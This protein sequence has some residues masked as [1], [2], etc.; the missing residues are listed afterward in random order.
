MLLN[1]YN[2]ADKNSNKVINKNKEHLINQ[3]QEDW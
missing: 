3:S 2:E 1:Y